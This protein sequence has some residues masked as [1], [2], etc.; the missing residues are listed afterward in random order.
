MKKCG[1]GR[2][3]FG[4]AGREAVRR[5]GGAV[6]RQNFFEKNVDKREEI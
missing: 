5:R 1:A 3:K 2:Q 4:R 6:P